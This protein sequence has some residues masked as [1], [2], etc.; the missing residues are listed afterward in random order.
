VANGNADDLVSTGPTLKCD[1]AGAGRIES[2]WR[3]WASAV[4]L[5]E[6]IRTVKLAKTVDGEGFLILKTV[7]DLDTAVQLY[8][9]DVEADQITTPAPKN[10]TELWV[11][12]LILHPITG[13]P[14]GY[15]VLKTHPGDYFFPTL[16]PLQFDR[17]KA[18]F[19]VHW[20]AKFRPGQVRGV[21]IFTSALD[22]FGE[23]RAY[24]KAILQKAQIAANLTA[25]LETEMPPDGDGTATPTPFDTLA[26]D[27]GVLTT[28]PTGSKLHQ[29]G[30]GEPGATYQEFSEQCLGEA[31]RPLSYPLNLALGTSQ[32]FNFSSARLDHINYRNGLT[33]ER[34]QCGTVVMD[35]LF[36]AW[37]DEAVMI[38]G[39]LPPGVNSI[40][41]VKHEWHWPGFAPLDPVADSTADH[42]RL[43]NGTLTW[44][45]FWAS[46]GYDWR[47]VMAQQAA[48]KDEIEK[49]GL[50][51]GDPLKKS[52]TITEDAGDAPAGAKKEP[53]N[54]K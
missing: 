28:L 46:R 44:Q 9:V 47:V 23:L 40:T 38:E 24:R 48:E 21:P 25:V 12:G 42:A 13:R 41:D 1:G 27:R 49:L 53:A 22:L 32:K 17:I 11:D 4:D 52:D 36:A 8:P 20:F 45:E 5:V 2:A 18:R 33:V 15:D 35:R 16:N 37:L 39:L 50:V 43:A 26:I 54:A 7:P 19:V 10:L 3:E 29:Y 6:K 14:T 34:D 51:F 31:C 30:S